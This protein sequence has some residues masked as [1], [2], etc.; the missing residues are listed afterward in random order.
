MGHLKLHH[1]FFLLRGLHVYAF[2]E[3][4]V[5]LHPLPSTSSY[6]TFFFKTHF[7][8]LNLIDTN[9]LFYDFPYFS[10]VIPLVDP[11]LLS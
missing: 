3:V 10:L 5:T 1:C 6:D 8:L 11:L 9:V 2:L 4:H 7:F